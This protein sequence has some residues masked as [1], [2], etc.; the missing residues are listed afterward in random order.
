[1]YWIINNANLIIIT[2]I[3]IITIVSHIWNFVE[4]YPPD[5]IIGIVCLTTI[6]GGVFS[7]YLILLGLENNSWI[8]AVGVVG[9]LYSFVVI[10]S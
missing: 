7:L 1:M 10:G 4:R 3:I 8:S 6:I 9:L 2:F 5:I